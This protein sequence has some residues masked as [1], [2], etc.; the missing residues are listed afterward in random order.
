MSASPAFPSS[1]PETIGDALSW[2]PIMRTVRSVK[3]DRVLLQAWHPLLWWQRL[4]TPGLMWQWG[5][6]AFVAAYL[7]LFIGILGLVFGPY[8]PI[9]IVLVVGGFV[10][11]VLGLMPFRHHTHKDQRHHPR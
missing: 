2:R 8:R 9:A 6:H 10:L 4:R 3:D 11:A 5:L 1:E 7:L